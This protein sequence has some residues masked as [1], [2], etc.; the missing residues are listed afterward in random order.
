[1]WEEYFHSAR[2]YRCSLGALVSSCSNTGLIESLSKTAKYEDE[3]VNDNFCPSAHCLGHT[4]FWVTVVAQHVVLLYINVSLTLTKQ[5]DNSS[6]SAAFVQSEV[7]DEFC[8]NIR[9]AW[10][11]AEERRRDM[12]SRLAVL[13]GFNS[14][15][16][17]AQSKCIQRS[18]FYGKTVR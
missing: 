10:T 9:S 3:D 5:R 1:M 8:Q 17:K 16:I 2:H 6:C 15:R 11:K 12:D 7:H 14:A 18:H 4:E 13:S